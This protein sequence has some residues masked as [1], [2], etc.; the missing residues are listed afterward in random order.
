[1]ANELRHADVI[2]GR[3]RENEYEHI[4]EHILNDQATGDMV[5]AS[6]AT[7]LS[8]LPIG[9]TGDFLTVTAGKPAWTNAFAVSIGFADDI[10]F[11]L[12]DDDDIALVLR[13][14]IL[15]INTPLANVLIGTPVTPAIAANS[16]I[17]SA[18]TADGDILMAGND[19]GNSKAF[20]F[21]DASTPDLYLYQVGGTWTAGATTW[22]I[23]AH[24]LSGS[25]TGGSQTM[26]G[27]GTING[28]A[29]TADTGAITSGSWTATVISPVYGGTGVANNVASTLT[30]TGA[31]ALTLTISNTT[32]ITLPTSGTLATLAGTE[33]LDN[34]TLDSSVAK[35]TW[36]TSGTWTI[37]AVTL[38]G[39]LTLNSQ[40]FDAGAGSLQIITTGE[41]VGLSIIGTMTSDQSVAMIFYTNSSSPAAEDMVA[42]LAFNGNKT[43]PTQWGFA[44]ERIHIVGL[45]VGTEEGRMEWWVTVSGFLNKAMTLS[46]V[47]LA[48]F[49]VGVNVDEYYQVASTQVVGARVIDARCDDAINS[50]DAT[51]DGVIDALR[52]AMISHGLIAAT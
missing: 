25:I 35:G 49:D 2:S 20:L 50:G 13:S 23:P 45:G 6:S 24:T 39:T 12:G 30:I 32:G 18:I 47:G 10:I 14:T 40:N 27:M 28:L 34:K 41:Q 16:L 19:G 21:F 36:T 3:V 7:Q 43:G 37:P 11:T 22:T 38:G 1:M 42:R 17:I 48:W 33:E 9:S 51:T 44:E 31:Y 52:D 46:G 5:Y 8:G 29:I 26:T 15:N 4:S